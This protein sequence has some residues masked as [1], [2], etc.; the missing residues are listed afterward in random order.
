MRLHRL[1]YVLVPVATLAST[2]VLGCFSGDDNAGSPG[3]DADV[4][5]AV[6]EDSSLPDVTTP[7]MEASAEAAT[8]APDAGDAG[9][10]ATP[11]VAEEPAPPLGVTIVVLGP[12]G[13]ESGVTIVFD[14]A[15]G[16]FVS[17]AMTD[18]SGRVTQVLAPNS[19]VTAVLGSADL[20]NLVTVT[21]VQPGDTLTA[22]DGSPQPSVEVQ[23]TDPPSPPDGTNALIVNAGDCAGSAEIDGNNPPV[24]V[25]NMSAPFCIGPTGQFPLLS[26]ATDGENGTLGYTYQKN[27][28]ITVDGG[29]SDITLSS[30]W[31]TQL[32][33]ETVSFT[34]APD[35]LNPYV[36]LGQYASAVPYTSSDS[37]PNV[38]D[39]GGA[40]SFETY[41]GYSDFLQAEIQIQNETPGGATD[42]V[43]AIRSGAPTTAQPNG[44]IA[45]DLSQ[46]LPSIT[47]VT[48]DATTPARPSATVTATS[49]LASTSGMFVTLDW[50]D[51][52]DGG[53]G[54]TVRGR[55]LVVGPPSASA[56]QFP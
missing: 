8:P 14:D 49:S 28:Q 37:E 24:L 26:L 20:A 54:A 22:I 6:P 31:Q 17:Q 36:L 19:M 30:A 48:V 10:G 15:S 44:T 53:S 47:G 43:M 27:F 3:I 40:S 4:D 32:G 1:S 41:P 12:G 50:V 13:P 45:F 29:T 51:V 7:P 9:G 46:L 5:S 16:A 18:A 33:Q 35:N 56:I 38:V 21:G 25:E 2:L 39:A 42:Q 52:P 55:W 11:D 34:N 23:V